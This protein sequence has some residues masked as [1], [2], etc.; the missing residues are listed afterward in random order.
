MKAGERIYRDRENGVFLG[1]C[2]G[3]A[4]WLGMRPLAVRVVAVVLLILKFLPT[5]L[6]Y[7]TAGL[8]LSDRPLTFR[9]SRSEREFWRGSHEGWR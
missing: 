5:A 4:A 8:L 6:V 7:L 3:V 9:G 1:V 2:A